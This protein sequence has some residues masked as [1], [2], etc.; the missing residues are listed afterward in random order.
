MLKQV[1]HRVTTCLKGLSKLQ[2]DETPR[3]KLLPIQER[4]FDYKF[5]PED[6]ERISKL[7]AQM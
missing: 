3:R 1:V 7:P 5:L 2:S 4:R 6:V